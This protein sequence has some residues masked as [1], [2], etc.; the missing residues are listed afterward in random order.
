MT[1]RGDKLVD[2]L[3]APSKPSCISGWRPIRTAL[4]SMRLLGLLLPA[5]CFALT[6]PVYAE[7]SGTAHERRACLS[8]VQRFCKRAVLGG[9]FSVLGCLQ[10]NRANI[11]AACKRVLS[12]RGV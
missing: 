8:D 2:I 11:S 1:R 3:C 12:A 9:D 5:L 6:I 7:P 4:C 10:Q